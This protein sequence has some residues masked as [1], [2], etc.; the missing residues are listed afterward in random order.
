MTRVLSR[1][2]VLSHLFLSDV[3]LTLCS[4]SGL[5]Q[6]LATHPAQRPP[7]GV[8]AAKEALVQWEGPL[9]LESGSNGQFRLCFPLLVV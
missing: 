9:F 3:P 6:L 2:V 1:Q 8:P 7:P 4:G 5:D